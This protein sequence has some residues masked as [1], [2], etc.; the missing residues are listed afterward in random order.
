LG[1]VPKS[2]L[3]SGLQAVRYRGAFASAEDSFYIGYTNL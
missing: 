3:V 1:P 2:H